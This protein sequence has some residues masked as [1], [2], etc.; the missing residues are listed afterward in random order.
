MEKYLIKG[1]KRLTG[2]I[3][4][5]SAKNSVLP[6]L[7]A[8]ILTDS[9]VILHKCPKILDV[10]NM[11]EILKSLGVK[12]T[13]QGSSLIINSSGISSFEVDES[14]AKELRSSIFLLGSILSRF[15]KAVA[16]KPGGCDIGI[17]PIDLHIKG[18]KDLNVKIKEENGKLECDGEN[19]TA[20]DIYL[21]YPSVGATENLIMASVFLDGTTRIFNPA[22][23]PEIVD[24]QDFINAMGGKISG[25]GTD[26]IEIIGVKKLTKVE[27]TPIADRI[28]VGTFLIGVAMSGGKIEIN[29]ADIKHS[30]ALIA[31]LKNSTCKISYKNG[32]IYLTAPKR[33][34]AVSKIETMPYPYFP[35]DLQSQILAMQTISNGTCIIKENMFETRFKHIAELIK[36]GAD[37]VVKDNVAIVKGVNNLYGT[38][39]NAY[40]LR[41]GASLVLAGIC[42][43]GETI[44]NNVY[45]ID[46]GY[47]NFEQTLNSLGADIVRI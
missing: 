40:D 22:K 16:S 18:L 4:I 44:I 11:L 46:R 1:E 21:D 26:K 29:G 31:K 20:N 2:K 32:T 7:S 47:E 5:Q 12:T 6:I 14:L 27:Y 10:F 36:M 8:S 9:E 45:H 33:L 13:W 34:K 35:T 42:G 23:E 19:M 25:A 43:V 37:I 28:A 3:D 39:L 17:R 41:G 15:K 24:L 38:T 30:Y